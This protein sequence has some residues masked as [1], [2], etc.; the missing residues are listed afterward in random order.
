MVHPVL[1]SEEKKRDEQLQK[2]GASYSFLSPRLSLQVGRLQQIQDV[3]NLEES[4]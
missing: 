3:S 1:T 2:F 4:S